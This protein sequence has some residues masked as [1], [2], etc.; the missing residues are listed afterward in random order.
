MHN[1]WRVNRL[2]DAQDRVVDNLLVGHDPSPTE[3]LVRWVVLGGMSLSASGPGYLLYE[4]APVSSVML[5]GAGSAKAA[6][7]GTV[8]MS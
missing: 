1:S 3:G 2:F 8:T 6:P 5:S 7:K 4:R